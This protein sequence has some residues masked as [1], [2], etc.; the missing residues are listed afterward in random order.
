[1]AVVGEKQECCLLLT[2]FPIFTTTK[3]STVGTPQNSSYLA[4]RRVS[5]GSPHLSTRTPASMKCLL[6]LLLLSDW[7]RVTSRK[8]TFQHSRQLRC[9]TVSTSDM[10]LISLPE[11]IWN[12]GGVKNKLK[13]YTQNELLWTPLFYKA[14]WRIV[15][16]LHRFLSKCSHTGVKGV[17]S[18]IIILWPV[19]IRSPV[20]SWNKKRQLPPSGV[21]SQDISTFILEA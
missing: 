15:Y 12:Q 14:P 13:E 3:L 20:T 19:E 8:P 17:F 11:S 21:F 1:M 4:V 18:P 6:L 7:P 5:S 16:S 2:P 9:H 10:H